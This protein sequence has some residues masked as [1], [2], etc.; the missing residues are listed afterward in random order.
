MQLSI[1]IPT[2]NEAE[3][4]GK[5]ILYL[6]QNS[7]DRLLEIIV[8][9]AIKTSD[10]TAEVAKL[11]GANKV[12]HTD[13]GRAK[14][15]N[16]GQSIAEGDI[17]YFIHADARP[18]VN[19][20][21]EIEKALSEGFKL[22]FFS[23]QHDSQCPLL[24]INGYCTRFDSIFTGGGDQTFF[25][26]ADTFTSIGR[27]DEN[28]LIMED[29][30]IVERIRAVKIPYKIIK[31]DVIVSARK[32]T[33]NGYVRVNLSNLIVFIMYKFGCSQKRLVGTYRWLLR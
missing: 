12:I 20:L 26:K 29:F 25:I 5:L 33:K 8:V 19:Y 24:K 21:D 22:G 14:Q 11:A 1:V 6:K 27:F 7:D 2:L 32:Y 3:N 30:E 18:P 13:T 16:R 4:I 31:N 15:M 17:F 23:Y 28:C 10:N 9:N